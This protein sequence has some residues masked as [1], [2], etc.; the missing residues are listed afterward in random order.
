M[1]SARSIMASRKEP[2]NSFDFFATPP[3]G[4]RAL[5]EAVLP[6]IGINPRDFCAWEPACGEGHMAEPLKEYFG[7]VLATDIFDYG[8]S[9]CLDFL[10]ERTD[11]V[12]DWIVTN[13]P[14]KA[15]LKFTER[16]LQ[17][18]RVGVAIFIRTQWAIEGCERYQRLFRDRPPTLF[19]PFVERV[20]LCKGKW[21]PDGSTAT[22]YCW[23]IWVK[24]RTPMPP[25]WI[26]PGQR[27][28]LTKPTDRGRFAAWS[29]PQQGAAE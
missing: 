4:T 24:N 1:K 16:A 15:S 26:P 7:Y 11:C 14:F 20:P 9:S 18:A 25:F 8:Y 23:L 6:H 17:L 21:D 10:D 5:C 28:L 19:A 12:S 29:L 13:P 22:A 3:W 2:F 27:K